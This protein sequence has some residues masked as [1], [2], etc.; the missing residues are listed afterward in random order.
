MKTSPYGVAFIAR[1]EGVVLHAY[2]DSVGVWTIGIGHTASAGQPQ[3][4]A[5]MQITKD[6]AYAILAQDLAKFEDRVN[7]VLP[8]VPQNVFDGAVSFDL[9]TG[10]ILSASWPNLFLT[11]QMHAAEI[12]LEQWNK[13]GGHVLRGLVNRRAAEADLIFRGIYGV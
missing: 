8:D 3:P 7:H 1:E 6:Q 4:I 10:G 5:G 12:H 13:A 11:D 9:N 2:R